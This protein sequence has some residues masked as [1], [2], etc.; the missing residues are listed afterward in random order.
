MKCINIVFFSLFITSNIYALSISYYS[1]ENSKKSLENEDRFII[2]EDLD[3]K[4]NIYGVFD[5]HGG[6]LVAEYLK[7]NFVNFFLKYL[8]SSTFK[9][10]DIKD[11]LGDFLFLDINYELEQKKIG[12]SMGST[13]N[14]VFIVDKKIYFTNVGDSRSVLFNDKDEI[15]FATTD[16]KPSLNSIR[17]KMMLCHGANLR[18]TI[19]FFDKK[20]NKVNK[21]ERYITVKDRCIKKTDYYGLDKKLYSEK[22]LESNFSLENFD[23]KEF[24]QIGIEYSKYD[25]T[26]LSLDSAFGDFNFKKYGLDANCDVTQIDLTGTEKYL[27]LATDGFWDKVGNYECIELIYFDL[28]LNANFENLAKKLCETARERGSKDDITVLVVKFK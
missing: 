8:L 22:D 1:L 19:G 17:T 3:K 5:G 20:D 18:H 26:Y 15:I 14:I 25:F 9:N 11:I 2:N 24:Y 7:E 27:V 12:F 23:K 10:L 6:S 28:K 21:F 13:A 4:I 16:Q